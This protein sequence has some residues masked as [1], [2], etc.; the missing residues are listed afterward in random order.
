MQLDYTDILKTIDAKIGSV[1]YSKEWI[2]GI[3]FNLNKRPSSFTFVFVH[4]KYSCY[5]FNDFKELSDW[6]FRQELLQKNFK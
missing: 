2:T 1:L 3:S 6:I 4:T 5:N